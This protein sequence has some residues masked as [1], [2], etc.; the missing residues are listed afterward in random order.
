MTDFEIMDFANRRTKVP[1][2]D[3]DHLG[4]ISN[5]TIVVITGDEIADIVWANGEEKS[6][7]SS[8]ERLIDYYDGCYTLF[9]AG[10]NI[11][12]INEFLERDDSYW[13]QNKSRKPSKETSVHCKKCKHYDSEINYC[14]MLDTWTYYDFVCGKGEEKDA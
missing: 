11:N 9:D 12:Y 10:S 7:D 1:G 14:C 2:V 5:I 13:F 3:L 8:S 4:E 6:F